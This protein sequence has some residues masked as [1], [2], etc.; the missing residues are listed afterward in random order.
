MYTYI[1][2][3]T[4]IFD[5]YRIYELEKIIKKNLKG[6]RKNVKLKQQFA[7]DKVKV[8][9]SKGLNNNNNNNNEIINKYEK[10]TTKTNKKNKNQNQKQSFEIKK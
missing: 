5:Y 3:C 6:R 10:K 1:Y 9:F 8:G 2:I 7:K 4:Y